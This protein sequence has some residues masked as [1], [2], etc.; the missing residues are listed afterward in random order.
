MKDL[1]V[2]FSGGR[3]S[4]YMCW[5]LIN[6]KSSEYNLHFVFANTGQEHEKTLEF[7]DKC[8][9]Y[10]N[11]NLTW[12]EA[13][14]NPLPHKGTTHKIVTYETAAR[15]GEP[16]E[17]VIKK[18]GIPNPTWQPCNREM[19]M[20][21]MRSLRVSIGL[22][23]AATAIGIRADE[24]DRINPETADRN[25]LVYPLAFWSPT[26]KEQIRHWW[27][28]Q[29]FDLE[30]PEHLGNC[31][32]CWKKSNRKLYTIAKEHPEYF[33]FFL[34]MESKYRDAGAGDQQRVF[35]RHYRSTEDILREAKDFPDSMIF[36]DIMPELQLDF[37]GLDQAG[38]ACGSESC[39]I[40]SD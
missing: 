8:D 4:A 24:C 7:V 16:F 3:T 12:V 30:I 31:V 6:Y 39:E 13:V 19:K 14:V 29:P 40:F 33:D 2:S 35:F 36:T 34:D 27:A 15:K 26:T 1:T 17:E 28:E 9:K 37:F 38:G 22:K 11:L 5:Y 18:Y 21:P 32:T 25:N 20:Q 23:D 10:F